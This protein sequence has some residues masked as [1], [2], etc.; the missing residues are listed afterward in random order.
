[1]SELKIE[2]IR[3]F[4]V[5]KKDGHLNNL[6]AYL[7]K[8]DELQVIIDVFNECNKEANEASTSHEKALDIDPVSQQSELLDFKE[9]WNNLPDESDDKLYMT[10]ETIERYLKSNY[11]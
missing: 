2:Q 6:F 10:N 7:E 11:G 8:E 4:V 1:M 3:Q 5:S 9:W